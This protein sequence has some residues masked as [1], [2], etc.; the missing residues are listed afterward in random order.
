[1][2][3]HHPSTQLTVLSVDIDFFV[4]GRASDLSLTSGLDTRLSSD[5]YATASLEIA[6]S[7]FEQ[8]C[9]LSTLTPVRG[10][11]IRHHDA[12]FE[13]L[14]ALAKK[15]SI[16]FVHMDA[17]A[18]LGLGDLSH[19]YLLTDWIRDCTRAPTRGWR[20][21]NLGSWLAFAAAAQL[22]SKIT[23][24]PHEP[25]S[26]GDPSDIHPL[27]AHNPRPAAAQE[28][29]FCPLT[30]TELHEI[31]L[32]KAY[33]EMIQRANCTSIPFNITSRDCF[34]L[35]SPPN[36]VILCQSPN[37]TP[38]EADPIFTLARSYIT[39]DGLG[40]SLEEPL[41]VRS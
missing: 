8:S 31:H 18:D 13:V 1:M 4:L 19:E 30:K 9:K 32:R 6:Q 2:T 5:E 22:V 12:A 10:I 35:L 26:S 36:F 15:G 14:R 24:V 16:N 38:V 33:A 34:N 41:E 39:E 37:F 3:T 21:L 29:R 25:L 17:H 7:V 11:S 28:L 40:L 20:G 27:Y 23:F